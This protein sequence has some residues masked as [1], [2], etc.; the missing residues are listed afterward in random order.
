MYNILLW[1]AR[2][3]TCILITVIER[4]VSDFQ[5]FPNHY[6]SQLVFGPGSLALVVYS[7]SEVLI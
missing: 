5:L 1:I 6:S 4:D 7:P 2:T 3:G